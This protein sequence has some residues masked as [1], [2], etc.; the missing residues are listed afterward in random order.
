MRPQRRLL[1]RIRPWAEAAKIM[2][3]VALHVFHTKQSHHREILEQRNG[4]E[5]AEI[6]ARQNRCGATRSAMSQ[7]ARVG[8]SFHNTFAI[9]MAGAD[10][11]ESQRSRQIPYPAL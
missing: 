5:I 7:Q 6:L 10:V 8:D 2:M 1:P 9:L 11:A 4:A 3:S